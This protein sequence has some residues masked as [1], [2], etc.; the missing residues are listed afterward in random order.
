MY[1]KHI[2]RVKLLFK[3]LIRHSIYSYTISM[4]CSH[5]GFGANILLKGFPYIKSGLM[6]YKNP[7]TI[8]YIEY[9]TKALL[10]N[11]F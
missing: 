6:G 10:E 7:I 1:K 4:V 3:P 11:T 8:K 2:S 5:F 9:L